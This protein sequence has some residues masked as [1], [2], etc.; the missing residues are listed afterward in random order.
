MSTDAAPILVDVLHTL[1]RAQTLILD[2]QAVVIRQLTQLRREV[3]E[4]GGTLGRLEVLDEMERELMNGTLTRVSCT[5]H[6][7]HSRRPF[8][9]TVFTTEARSPWR[10]VGGEFLC[11]ELR[12]ICNSV[13]P[14]RRGE[15]VKE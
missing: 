11:T 15:K 2:Q 9:R 13:P 5:V 12:L 1:M 10:S 14:R 4:I 3:L 6:A 8:V 7:E